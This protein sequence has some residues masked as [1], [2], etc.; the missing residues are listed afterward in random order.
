MMSITQGVILCMRPANKRRRYSVTNARSHWPGAYTWIKKRLSHSDSTKPLQNHRNELNNTLLNL[1]PYL[2]WDNKLITDIDIHI[3]M[4]IYIHVFKNVVL[5]RWI[6]HTHRNSMMTSSNGYIFR[7]TGPLCGEFTG[8][9]WIP[10]TKA[11]DAELLMFPL[12]CAWTNG[13]LNNRDTDDLRRHCAHYDVTVMLYTNILFIFLI[14]PEVY[15]NGLQ[16]HQS[17]PINMNHNQYNQYA[18]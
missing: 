13:H 5:T 7:V 1:L 17:A 4:Y 18:E 3:Y 8:H 9:R 16:L 2:I 10:L 6:Y 12:I 11:S 14:R 15:S